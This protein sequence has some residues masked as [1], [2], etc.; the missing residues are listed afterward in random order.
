MHFKGLQHNTEASSFR[1]KSEKKKI[2]KLQ[3]GHCY[4][5]NEGTSELDYTKN[6]KWQVLKYMDVS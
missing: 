2:Q 3:S 1:R 4:T 5:T 6:D